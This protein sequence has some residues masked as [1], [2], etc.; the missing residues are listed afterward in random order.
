MS[1]EQVKSE[2]TK[3]KLAIL[4]DY[5]HVALECADWSALS[6]RVDITVFDTTIQAATDLDALIKRLEPFHI[7]CS[8]RERTKFSREVLERL[9]NLKLLA[10]TGLRNAAID[11]EAAADHGIIVSYTGYSG[12]GTNEHKL[13]SAI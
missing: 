1:K 12:G 7:I 8:M 11:L 10:T 9:P 2:E 6:S 3:P 13:S 5:Q 4:D